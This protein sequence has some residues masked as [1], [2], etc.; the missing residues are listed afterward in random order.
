MR[1]NTT[2]LWALVIA[3]VIVLSMLPVMVENYLYSFEAA[4]IAFGMEPFLP[5]LS[6]S[7]YLVWMF[8]AGLWQLVISLLYLP[9]Y[10][11]AELG[12][13]EIAKRTSGI[14]PEAFRADAP[15]ML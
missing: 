14:R 4:G 15:D 12:Y 5:V 9:V 1:S 7:Q 8:A 13:Y 10:T 11:C 3:A 2:R 6:D